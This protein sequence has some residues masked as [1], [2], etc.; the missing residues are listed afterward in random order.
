MNRCIAVFIAGA[1]IVAGCSS[2]EDTFSSSTVSSESTTTSAMAQ[3]STTLG[4]LDDIEIPTS[5]FADE[6][7]DFIELMV[8]KRIETPDEL[9]YL[10]LYSEHRGAAELGGEEPPLDDETSV[11]AGYAACVAINDA[12][13]HNDDPQDGMA[14]TSIALQLVFKVDLAHAWDVLVS[15]TAALCDP[16][17][18]EYFVAALRAAE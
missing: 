11:E 16:A 9:L 14:S 2:G 10:L 5:Q 3:S 1:L 18:T 7:A 15:S 13:S 8:S 6:T 4:S 12:L 17:E